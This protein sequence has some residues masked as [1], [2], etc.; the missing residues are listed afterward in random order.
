[1]DGARAGRGAPRTRDRV[2]RLVRPLNTL[3]GRLVSWLKFC[4]GNVGFEE[5]G[6][7]CVARRVH[8]EVGS[9]QK[10]GDWWGENERGGA[11]H[12]RGSETTSS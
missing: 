5:R 2:C 8:D 4:S 1:M 7:R 12:A 10:L 9:G 6:G 11:H 3:A